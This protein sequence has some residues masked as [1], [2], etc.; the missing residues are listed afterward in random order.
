M[1]ALPLDGAGVGLCLTSAGLH[2][3]P[4]PAAARAVMARCVR[5]GGR[6]VATMAV[7]GAGPRQDGLIALYRR[8][9][10]FG[11]TG[12]DARRAG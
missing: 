10:I 1:A 7:K 3:F 9:G 8:L 12:L 6:L 11:P 2:C 5:P 4:E